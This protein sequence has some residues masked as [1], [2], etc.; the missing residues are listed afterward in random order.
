MSGSCHVLNGS[1]SFWGLRANP[2]IL[3]LV[4]KDH[5]WVSSHI[6]TKQDKTASTSWH[7]C[8][9][10]YKVIQGNPGFIMLYL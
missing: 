7:R 9:K 6:R 2:D 3:P 5:L 10:T 8:I 1:S 4:V